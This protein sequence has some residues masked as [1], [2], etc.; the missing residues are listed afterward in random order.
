MDLWQQLFLLFIGAAF[1]VVVGIIIGVLI[2]KN[3]NGV[4]EETTETEQEGIKYGSIT[5]DQIHTRM[6]AEKENSEEEEKTTCPVCGHVNPP[7]NLFCYDCGAR[8]H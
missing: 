4:E 8:L 7:D 2:Q 1:G 6:E 5:P 3:R